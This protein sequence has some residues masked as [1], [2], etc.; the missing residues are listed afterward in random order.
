MRPIYLH[1]SYI[2]T[3]EELFRKAWEYGFQGV[4]T[5]SPGL[6][7]SDDI[8]QGMDELARLKEYWFVQ[9]MVLHFPMDLITD[10]KWPSRKEVFDRMGR[11]F[12]AASE[13]LEVKVF[14]TMT[15]GALI[16]PGNAYTDYPKNGSAAANETHWERAVEMLKTACGMAAEY[17]ITLVMETHGCLLH[18]LPEPTLK[19][20]SLVAKPNL[21]INLD[22]PNMV[23][24]RNNLLPAKE[25]ESLLP[26]TGHVHLKNLRMVL[27]GGYLLE[28]VG[29][30]IIDY[31]PLF[32]ALQAA[33][34]NGGYSLEFPGRYG[35]MDKALKADAEFVKKLFL[36]VYASQISVK[37]Q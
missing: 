6:R 21:K 14:N 20:L 34:Y 32:Q 23:L 3:N 15:A 28:G 30:G 25:L 13:K 4:E 27:G 37:I 24:S 10:N 19:L 12:R 2:T 1:R 22:L 29:G 17:G 11:A 36:E 35:D 16:P 5:N 31:K 7:P 18:D 33:G 8:S 26:L 9:G